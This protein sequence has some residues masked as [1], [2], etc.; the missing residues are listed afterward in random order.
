V[1]VP[2]IHFIIHGDFFLCLAEFGVSCMESREGKFEAVTVL[3]C[4][5][6]WVILILMRVIPVQK[7]FTILKAVSQVC[8]SCQP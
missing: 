3:P 6:S 1:F 4:V 8:G 7:H 2:C 5:A